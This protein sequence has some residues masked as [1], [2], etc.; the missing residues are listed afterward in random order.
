MLVGAG[1]N[2]AVQVGKDGVLLVDT[3]GAQMTDQVL[4]T[5][6]QLAK[7]ITNRPIRFIIN[8][9][10]HPDHTGGNEKLRAAGATIT[11]GNGARNRA[12]ATAGA[13]VLARA[14]LIE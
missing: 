10:F 2:I 8:T 9:H 14:K 12:V 1:G 3:G 7:P 11:G 13:A 4:A 6:K 5:V